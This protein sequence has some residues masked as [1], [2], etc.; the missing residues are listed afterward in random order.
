MSV[1]EE[2]RLMV[3]ERRDLRK[4]YGPTQY[5]DGTWG[6]KTKEEL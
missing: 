2:N 6:I 4:I 1:T 5:N 3:F